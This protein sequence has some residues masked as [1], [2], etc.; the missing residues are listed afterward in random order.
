MTSRISYA[1][2]WAPS[3]S[4]LRIAPTQDILDEFKKRKE[5]PWGEYED[6]FLGLMREREIENELAS[7]EFSKRTVLLCSEDTPEYCH[8]RLVA[9]YLRDRWKDVE[10]VHL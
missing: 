6:R 10:I 2:W 9:E 3:T 5:M 8:R 1:P 4:T 7:E